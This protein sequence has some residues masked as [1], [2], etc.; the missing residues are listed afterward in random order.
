MH[1]SNYYVP[2]Y[3]ISAQ[4]FVDVNLKF[5]PLTQWLAESYS[6]V[7]KTCNLP[8][9]ACSPHLLSMSKWDKVVGPGSQRPVLHTSTGNK[10]RPQQLRSYK[11]QC[12][13]TKVV[14]QS[15]QVSLSQRVLLFLQAFLNLLSD[16]WVQLHACSQSHRRIWRLCRVA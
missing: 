13:T 15:S 11:Y 6:L 1:A 5:A 4:I 8:S 14:F 7:A 9:L 2:P 16:L 3:C 10:R 12:E